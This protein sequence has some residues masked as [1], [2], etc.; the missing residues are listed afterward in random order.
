MAPRR[1]SRTA[2]PTPGVSL[3][4]PAISSPETEA[5]QRLL[6]LAY[7]VSLRLRHHAQ[8]AVRISAALLVAA[9]LAACDGDSL[10]DGQRLDAAPVVQPLQREVASGLPSQP[11]R[12]PL[13]ENSLQR[14]E[15]GVY[16]FA[17]RPAGAPGGPDATAQA[18]R[19]RLVEDSSELLEIPATGD[20]ILHLRPNSEVRLVPATFATG[21]GATP[22]VGMSSGSRS[23]GSGGSGSG[24]S[25]SWR[26]LSNPS[27]VRGPAYY[28]PPRSIA[29]G[30]VVVD[31]ARAS[32]TIASPAD[33]T[34]GVVHAVSG[35]A[36]G[37]GSGT[38]ASNRAGVDVAGRSGGAPGG[39]AASK[40]AGFSGGAATAKGG[41]S[42]S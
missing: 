8:P 34:F 18:S 20:P 19:V 31:G 27:G 35:R 41:A 33:R 40:S 42:S 32:T 13:V 38:A 12:Y 26:P 10:D 4:A 22:T 39:V 1:P 5:R 11:G 14:D 25:T 3:A 15:Q 29:S 23:M 21:I 7:D 24:T 16:A 28:D 6:D 30:S 37:A 9:S 17:Y 36:G 2:S